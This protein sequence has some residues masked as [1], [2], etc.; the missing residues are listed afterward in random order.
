MLSMLLDFLY[1]PTCFHCGKAVP[2]QGMW[3]YTCF[4]DVLNIRK[5]T[6][7]F[8]DQLHT[9]WILADYTGGIKSMMYDVKFNA[10]KE[11]ARGAAPFLVSFNSY[12]AAGELD[13]HYVIPIPVSKE[14]KEKRGYNQVELFFYDWVNERYKTAQS[15][16]KNIGPTNLGG[17]STEK[18]M[19]LDCLYKLSSEEDMWHLSGN[20]RRKQVE[21]LFFMNQDYRQETNLLK[22][23]DILL[24]DDVYTT[25]AT[26]E[27]AASCLQRMKPKT[28]KALTLGSGS[29]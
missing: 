22:G 10:K 21:N 3:C 5:V 9:V 7:D 15:L 2:K 16:E 25:G 18:W 28:I 27:A 1:P 6:E 24:V 17:G 14:R 4:N 20:A 23:K 29:F 26:L 11:H 8:L 12:L 19:W 13:P